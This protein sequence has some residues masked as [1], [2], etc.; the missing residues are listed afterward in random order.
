MTTV[1]APATPYTAAEIVPGFAY[2]TFSG[3]VCR[4]EVVNPG[5]HTGP[6]FSWSIPAESGSLIRGSAEVAFLVGD[7][8]AGIT[9]GTWI[10]DWE[11]RAGRP[12]ALDIAYDGDDGSAD[13]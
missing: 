4:V 12:K 9:K 11:R 13:R 8:N 6:W 1:A 5:T 2:R 10:L 7:L 3:T